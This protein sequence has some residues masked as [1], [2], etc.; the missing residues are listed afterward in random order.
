MNFDHLSRRGFLARSP[1]LAITAADSATKTVHD[2][3]TSDDE[4]DPRTSTQLDLCTEWQFRT[5]PE[6]KGERSDW[7]SGAASG[8]EW[9]TVTVPHTWQI[10]APLVNFRGDAWYTKTFFVP[11]SWAQAVVRVEFEAVFHSATVWVN[12][13]MAGEHLRKGYTAF[14]FDISRLLRFGENNTIA[15]RVN[16]AFNED[17]LPR[18]HSSDWA[19]DGGIY[20]PARLLITNRVYAERIGIDAAPDFDTGAAELSITAYLVSAVDGQVSGTIHIRVVDEQTGN[21]V[22]ADGHPT[23]FHAMGP[24]P[25][26]VALHRRLERAQFWHFDNPHLYRVK[27]TTLS[28]AGAELFTTTFGVRRLEV[29]NGAFYFNNEKVILTGVERMAGSNPEFGMAEPLEWIDHDHRDLKHLNCIFTRVHWPQDKRVLEFCDRHGILMQ[30]EVPAWGPST[31][32]GMSSVPDTDI[33]Q[34]GLEQLREMV[35][36]DRNHPCIVTWGLCNEINGQNPPAYDFAKTMLAEAKKLDPTRLCS[37]ASHSLFHTQAKDVSGLMDFIECNQYFGSWQRG[38]APELDRLMEHIHAAFPDKPIV[39]SEYG[40]CACTADRPEGDGHRE[41]VLASQNAVL[42]TKPFV[43][44]A[45]FFCYN[46]YRT[47]VGDRGEGVMQQ[48]VHGVVDLYGTP[49][50]SYALLRNEASPIETLTFENFPLRVVLRVKTRSALPA[51]KLRGYS[52]RAL[53]F[54]SENI[55]AKR[56]EQ[57][58]PELSPGADAVL[59]FDFG[60]P[61]PERIVFDVLRPTRFSAASLEWLR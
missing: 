50:P 46:D 7:Q 8:S 58:L 55:P 24:G 13:Q 5:D 34:N 20:R 57:R 23:S 14:T 39:I 26:S 59:S 1:A 40:Y 49:K 15:V 6:S 4:I 41:S 27:L 28:Q 37:Y 51:Y 36:R 38:G 12:G 54:E 29:R 45:I 16:N 30:E 35:G 53:F 10:E 2:H 48:R 31:F 61:Q 52:V 3:P 25:F 56:L 22:L 60:G 17:M 44:G 19:L 42:R 21:I 11:S 9:R 33:M 43:A 47:H 32:A 18:G